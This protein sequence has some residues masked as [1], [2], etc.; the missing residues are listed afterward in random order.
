[1]KGAS[2]YMFPW[3]EGGSISIQVRPLLFHGISCVVLEDAETPPP[4]VCVIQDHFVNLGVR[5]NYP[6]R[7]GGRIGGLRIGPP[8]SGPVPR[9]GFWLARARI[10][11]ACLEQLPGAPERP[12]PPAQDGPQCQF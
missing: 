4:C 7:I 3:T 5:L 2:N 12:S 10:L 8:R 1:M 6:E 9:S 11:R